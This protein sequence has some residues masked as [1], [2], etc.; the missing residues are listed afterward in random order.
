MDIIWYGHSCFRFRNEGIS[1]ITDPFPDSIGLSIGQPD[2]SI[3]TVS[4]H[5]PNHSYTAGVSDVSNIIDGPGEYDLQGVHLQGIVTPLPEGDESE[6]RNI[7]YLIELA[8]ITLL[9]LG[10]AKSNFPTRR[11]EELVPVDVLL[12]PA[13]GMCTLELDQIV[14]VIQN[15]NPKLVIPMH[16]RH[17]LVDINLEAPDA[18]LRELGVA[19]MTPQSKLTVTRSTLP[20]GL[21]VVLMEVTT[22]L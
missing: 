5:H 12:V 21:Q 6:T 17:P 16:Y 9:H 20:Q 19:D 2:A 4:N 10:D 1:V 7:A 3:V 8:G 15:L 18:L 22:K 14:T 13:G 11:V